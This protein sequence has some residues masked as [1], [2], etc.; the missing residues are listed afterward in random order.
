MTWSEPTADDNSGAVTVTSTH[1][2]G[3]T[4]PIGDT[5]VAY[6]AVDASVN[7]VTRSFTITVQG[8]V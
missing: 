1:S 6:T 7:S 2:S 5:L 3:D 8:M 4:F